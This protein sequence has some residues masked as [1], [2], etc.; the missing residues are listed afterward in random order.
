MPNAVVEHVYRLL[1]SSQTGWWLLQLLVS[2]GLVGLVA[3]RDRR[4]PGPREGWGMFVLFAAHTA[5]MWLPNYPRPELN[6]DEGQWIAQANDL[7]REPVFWVRHFLVWNW[8]RVLTILPLAAG[9]MLAGAGIGYSGARLVAA[10]LWAAF[11]ASHFVAVREVFGRRAALWS[12]TLVALIIGLFSLDDFVAYNSELPVIVLCMGATALLARAATGA[13]GAG[14]AFAAGVL[15]AA[16]PFAKDQGLPIAA[17]LGCG[18]LVLLWRR[19]PRLAASLVTGGAVCWLLLPL[20]LL[21]AGGHEEWLFMLRSSGEYWRH[22][23]RFALAG[24]ANRWRIAKSMFLQ[25]E[26]RLL[27]YGTLLGCPFL[28]RSWWSARWR[29]DRLQLAF[30]AWAAALL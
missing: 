5:V 13:R 12:S 10:F 11:S 7:V 1:G 29:P 23:T 16:V 17:V 25:P 22:G 28:L 15:V 21:L 18:G 2:A 20:I 4:G 19:Q 14:S 30:T 3:V 24:A 9:G 8:S 26:L 27:L 6:P